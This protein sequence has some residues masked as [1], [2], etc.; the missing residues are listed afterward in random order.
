MFRKI[1]VCQPP[2]ESLPPNSIIK[3]YRTQNQF[4][5]PPSYLTPDLH[6]DIGDVLL[7]ITRTIYWLLWQPTIYYCTICLVVCGLGSSNSKTKNWHQFILILFIWY[8]LLIPMFFSS[9]RFSEFWW[10]YSCSILGPHIYTKVI[11]IS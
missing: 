5:L 1:R 11:L 7:E 8:E 6:S 9:S 2:W 10:L 4:N 3:S